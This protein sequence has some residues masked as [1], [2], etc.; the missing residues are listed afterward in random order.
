MYIEALAAAKDKI[1]I[2][3]MVDQI[4]NHKSQNSTTKQ[5]NLKNVT[6]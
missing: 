1:R 3:P 5:N 4:K 6:Y 2:Q